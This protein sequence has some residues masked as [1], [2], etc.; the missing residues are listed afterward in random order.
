MPHGADWEN[1]D[2]AFEFDRD[3]PETVSSSCKK[4]LRTPCFYAKIIWA[5]WAGL[6][7]SFCKC[8][9]MQIPLLFIVM[10]QQGGTM[11]VANIRLFVCCHRPAVVPE[12]PLLVPVQVG[13]ALADSHFPGF[14]HDDAGDNISRENRSYCELTAQYWAWKNVR[15]DCCGF[16]HY[17][18]YLYPDRS[19]KQP[20]RI[21]GEP[22][23]PLLDKLGYAALSDLISRYD[24]ILPKGEDMHVPVRE[25]Y[26]QAPFHHG[27]DLELAER[28]V[29]ERHPEM[30]QAMEQY[31]SGSIC[32]FGNIH[33]MKQQAFHDYCSWL[34]PILREFDRRADTGNY[35]AQERRVDGYLAERLLGIYAV[36]RRDLKTLELPRVHFIGD[37]A[38]RLK[39][40]AVNLLLP[41]GSVRRSRIKAMKR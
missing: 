24:L 19:A 30:A 3:N 12:H 18:R 16:F 39:K 37:P 40:Q 23:L 34:F 20:Y 33:I 26:A 38:E 5:F 4:G 21:E 2:K 1:K 36:Y 7:L 17:R 10:N 9:G 31:L 28:I 32:Y 6:F 35:T 41:P 22:A 25:H 15:A 29:R 11:A 14:L 13:A 27:R 8:F